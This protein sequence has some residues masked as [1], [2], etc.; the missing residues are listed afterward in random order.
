MRLPYMSNEPAQKLTKNHYLY[1]TNPIIMKH[2]IDYL[3]IP[4][5]YLI[6]LNR[7]CPKAG[8]CLRQLAAEAIPPEVE[9]LN[10]INPAYLATLKRDCPHYRVAEKACYAKGFIKM[11]DSMSYKQMQAVSSSLRDHFGRPTYFRMRKGERLLSPAEQD[12][13][14]FFVKR[15]GVSQP[16]DFDE[17]VEK[18]K[19]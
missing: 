12:D 10:I 3:Q 11:L 2:R 6:C 1:G 16:H 19:W 14:L 15:C 9:Q 13:L 8:D 18:Y 17:Y 5:S 7:E 4:N